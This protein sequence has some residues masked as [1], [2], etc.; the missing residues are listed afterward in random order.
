MS[1]QA[2]S[3][4]YEDDVGYYKNM[5]GNMP[6]QTIDIPVME[7]NWNTSTPKSNAN[8]R[9]I[10]ELRENEKHYLEKELKYRS[11]IKDLEDKLSDVT[12]MIE[13]KQPVQTY[14]I[15]NDGNFESDDDKVSKQDPCLLIS[16]F[17]LVLNQ[18]LNIG[19][20]KRR[21]Q[22]TTK[23]IPGTSRCIEGSPPS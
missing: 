1:Y 7:G 5:L 4:K 16:A 20:V 13:E 19:W 11:K 21:T 15:L 22:I 17:Y 23:R 12:K 10:S 8:D 3:A 6:R 2:L 9:I 18:L 14:A